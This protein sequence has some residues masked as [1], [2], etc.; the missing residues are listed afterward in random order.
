MGELILHNWQRAGLYHAPAAR[1]PR[2]A[3]AAV[4]GL[5]PCRTAAVAS[6][7]TI[8]E[9][10]ERLGKDLAFPDYYGSNLD[11]L[12]DCLTDPDWQAEAGLVLL[13]QGLGALRSGDPEGFSRLIEVLSSAAADRAEANI[14]CWIILDT[15]ARGV[16][17]L[18]T[19]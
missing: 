2:L 11:A 3:E 17:K 8:A 16:P 10:L 15:P 9:A 13:I 7:R 6:C 1:H 18:P 19:A 4:S 12:H 5:H 14:P